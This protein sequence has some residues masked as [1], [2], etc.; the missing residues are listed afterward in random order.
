MNKN[1]KIIKPCEQYLESYLEA[2]KEFK[3]LGIK[4]G[5]PHDP[6]KFDEWKDTIFTK[7]EE[8]SKGINLPDGFVPCTMYWMVNDNDYIG[9]GNIRHELNE[10]LK[11]FGGHIGY[12]I[13]KKYWNKGY[14]SLQLKL[15]LQKCNEMGIEKALLTCDATNIA[16]S[17]VM[18]KNGGKKLGLYQVRLNNK[19]KF[20]Y[21]YEIP[22]NIAARE[23]A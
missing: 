16:S 1:V 14:G 12:H 10:N 15:L 6:D 21:K 3:E 17:R 9:A 5:P 8:Y 22:T 20:I 19:L 2:C 7:C 23:N 13:R 18:E 11:A 4:S